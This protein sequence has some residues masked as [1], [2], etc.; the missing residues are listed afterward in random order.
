MEEN[1]TSASIDNSKKNG[2]QT[3]IAGAI[4]IA[5]LFI[6]GAILL[7]GGSAPIAP[8]TAENNG[9]N[10]AAVIEAPEA[11][12]AEDY[13]IGDPR[14]R[15]VLIEYADFQCPFC[16]RFFK[17]TTTVLNEKYIQTGKIK[18]VYRDFAFLG[19]ESIKSAEAAR[20]AGD[21]NKFWEY[22]DYLFTHQNGENKGAF[23]NDNLKSF[24]KILGLNEVV[25]NQC[26]DS[27][28]YEKAVTDST[29]AGAQAGVRGT[30]K[31]FILKN[32]K[33][34]DTIDG[35]IPT[36]IVI[37]KIENALKN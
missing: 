28:K 5:G 33:V 15:V 12:S 36:T 34:V 31:G 8:T 30:P 11:I 1:N 19:E 6:A 10:N 9:N 7:R 3:Q 13:M 25:F 4:L 26:L 37:E 2:N 23:A 29:D 14:A 32:G 24:A 20:C 35:A 16:G 17:D 18:F 27:A 21:Q 22:H